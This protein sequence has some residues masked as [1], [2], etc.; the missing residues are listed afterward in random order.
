MVSLQHFHYCQCSDAHVE[1]FVDNQLNLPYKVSWNLTVFFFSVSLHATRCNFRYGVE[2][3]VMCSVCISVCIC[4]AGLEIPRN[5]KSAIFKKLLI[6]IQASQVV[7]LNF[8]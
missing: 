7:L 8:I 3:A 6:S 4:L 5:F 1:T 2:N